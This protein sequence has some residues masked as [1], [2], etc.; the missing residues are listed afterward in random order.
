MQISKNHIL[1]RA[2]GEVDKNGNL[3][4]V[5]MTMDIPEYIPVTICYDE[6]NR[7]GH[8][9]NAVFKDGLLIGD[10]INVDQTINMGGKY[11]GVCLFVDDSYSENA[12]IQHAKLYS[13]GINRDNVDPEILPIDAGG[14]VLEDEQK[15]IAK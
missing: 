1:F 13:I 12:P 6:A 14:H 9:N 7:I 11:P 8:I 3:Y 10:I 15:N 5:D 4:P 2:T